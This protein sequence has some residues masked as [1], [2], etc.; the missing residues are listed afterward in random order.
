MISFGSDAVKVEMLGDEARFEAVCQVFFALLP[1]QRLS[2]YRHA[3]ASP[4]TSAMRMH[5]EARSPAAKDEK[6]LLK[7]RSLLCDRGD[8]LEG[9]PAFLCSRS[10]N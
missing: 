4:C 3:H 1:S 5:E 9:V 7:R 6:P 8:T 10:P 2:P